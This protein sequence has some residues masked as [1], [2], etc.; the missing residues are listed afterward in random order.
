MPPSAPASSASSA[1]QKL[2]GERSLKKRLTS[3]TGG[4][5]GL[6]ESQMINVSS[7][8]VC[9][10]VYEGFFDVKSRER[11]SC[12]Q[13]KRP[14][15]NGNSKKKSQTLNSLRPP[16]RTFGFPSLPRE[17]VSLRPSPRGARRSPSMSGRAGRASLRKGRGERSCLGSSWS[18]SL[19]FLNVFFFCF[20]LLWEHFVRPRETQQSLSSWLQSK[21]RQWVLWESFAGCRTNERAVSVPMQLKH[22]NER[23]KKKV[24]TLLFCR[25]V[26]H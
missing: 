7:G 3:P 25:V 13:K 20:F 11:E 10:F 21:S 19:A 26:R 5:P 16:P 15:G 2:G 8:F 9:C 22:Q 12:R 18:S 23:E 4:F 17:S 1:S 24:L 14:V 6:V